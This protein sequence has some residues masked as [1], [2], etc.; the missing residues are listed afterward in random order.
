MKLVSRGSCT[1]LLLVSFVILPVGVYADEGGVSFWLPGQ[2]GSLSAAPAQP[3]WS[4]AGIYY[5]TSLNAGAGKKLEIGGQVRAGLDVR[6]DLAFLNATYVSPQPVFGGQAAFGLTGVVGRMRASVDATLT[7]PLGNTLSGARTDTITDIGDLYPMATLKW[8][9][10]VHNYMTYLTGDI[11]VG[12]YSTERIANL[13]IG[14]AAVDGG[15]GY[16][17]FDPS[18]GHEFSFVTGLTYNF[19]NPD[20]QYRNGLGWHLD[21]AASQF[22]S[23]QVHVGLVG[24]IYNQLGADGG[25]GAAL[26][27][28][29]SRVLGVGPQVGYI[30]PIGDKW[31][32]Y[33][34][35]KGY[36]EFAAQNRPEGWNAWLVFNISPAAVHQATQAKITK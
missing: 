16:T 20:T 10:G 35:V 6:A 31:Q 14:H 36:W 12:A 19:E 15:I 5:H 11:P 22:L 28:F 21:W 9:R 8:N 1:F 25:A 2:F 27:P 32:G 23:E 34:N 3:G 4:F 30:F 33:L 13:G 26:G 29:R 24:Y 17:Y 7:G 18:K